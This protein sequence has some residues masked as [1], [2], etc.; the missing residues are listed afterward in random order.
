MELTNLGMTVVRALAPLAGVSW[1]VSMPLLAALGGN[2]DWRGGQGRSGRLID[3]QQLGGEERRGPWQFRHVGA[4][5]IG[6]ARRDGLS[7]RIKTEVLVIGTLEV[8]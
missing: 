4:A 3:V 8:E 1:L 2:A 7:R 5:G 6:A